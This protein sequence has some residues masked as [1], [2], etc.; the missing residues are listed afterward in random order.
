MCGKN[1]CQDT[2]GE[3]TIAEPAGFCHYVTFARGLDNQWPGLPELDSTTRGR[4][5][6]HST[7]S[8]RRALAS[9]CG[10]PETAGSVSVL[11][12]RSSVC[13][14]SGCHA[15]HACKARTM[16]QLFGGAVAF[17]L[18]SEPRNIARSRKPNE[19]P[20]APS[21]SRP[22]TTAARAHR[23]RRLQQPMHP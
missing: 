20:S 6:I 18:Q 2:C 7:T 3:P 1:V 14:T 21:P 22:P 4:S 15:A 8:A 9:G 12:S 13:R 5:A 23:V 17:K 19:R 16:A 11:R 10:R